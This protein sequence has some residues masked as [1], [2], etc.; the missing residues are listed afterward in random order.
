KGGMLK[1]AITEYKVIKFF[2]NYSLIEVYPKTGRTHQIRVHLSSI[3]HPIIG[4]GLYGP[5]Q[6]PFGL[7]WQFLHAESLEF[8]IPDGGRIKIEAELSEELKE[9]LRKID[10]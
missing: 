8:N 1:E 10:I 6:N 4:D 9:I 2:N 3:G 7:K 5:K